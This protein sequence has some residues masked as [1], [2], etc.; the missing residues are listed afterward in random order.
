MI[1]SPVGYWVE[2][3]TGDPCLYTLEDFSR[4]TF[5]FGGEIRG[6]YAEPQHG[7]KQEPAAYKGRWWHEAKDYTYN[8]HMDPDARPLYLGHV[9]HDPDDVILDSR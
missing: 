7:C 3:R 6:L 1:S 8:S 9:L 2:F 4:E 5:A